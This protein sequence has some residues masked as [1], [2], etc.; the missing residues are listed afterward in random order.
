M[1]KTTEVPLSEKLCLSIAEAS[2][3]SGIGVNTISKMLN[4]PDCP[5]LLRVGKKH[6]MVRR[7]AFEEFIRNNDRII[8]IE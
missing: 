7:E 3:Y 6:R 2:Q 4:E 5:F 1:A 8:G